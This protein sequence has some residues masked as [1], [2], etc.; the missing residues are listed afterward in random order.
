MSVALNERQQIHDRVEKY[1]DT[2]KDLPTL[3]RIK[4]W[5]KGYTNPRQEPFIS[6]KEKKALEDGHRNFIYYNSSPAMK[7]VWWIRYHPIAITA[8]AIGVIAS[9]GILY[10]TYG[11]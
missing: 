8:T 1:L 10:N 9:L 7:V 3:P 11:R 2:A 5:P 6:P 4:G